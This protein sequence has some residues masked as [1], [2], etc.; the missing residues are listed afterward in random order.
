MRYLKLLLI[1]LPEPPE[2]TDGDDAC[3]HT[4]RSNDGPGCNRAVPAEVFLQ[5]REQE[6]R[7][8]AAY[9]GESVEQ[10]GYKGDLVELIEIPRDAGDEHQ[11]DKLLEELGEL[12]TAI[13]KERQ[14]ST[15]IMLDC[16]IDEIADVLIMIEQYMLIKG[17]KL[18][19]V[20]D[21]KKLK[22]D[23]TLVRMEGI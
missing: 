11:V 5:H 22:V 14:C 13:I 4:Q 8:T 21:R 19:I 17:I 2:D 9:I 3:D 6:G 20:N 16:V 7:C 12:I 18:K 1:F 15:E 10:T 23:R